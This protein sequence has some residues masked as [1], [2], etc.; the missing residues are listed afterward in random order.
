MPVPCVVPH[1]RHPAFPYQRSLS[2]SLCGNFV[3]TEMWNFLQCSLGFLPCG[4]S[5]ARFL[6][7]GGFGCVSREHSRV[8]VW[9]RRRVRWAAN[10]SVRHF[11]TRVESW[12]PRNPVFVVC[13]DEDLAVNRDQSQFSPRLEINR[14]PNFVWRQC[15]FRGQADGVRSMHQSVGGDLCTPLEIFRHQF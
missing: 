13:E 4:V 5:L 15:F 6:R 8:R 12:V 7:W 10:T 14:S 11:R 9:V 3:A 1:K 2:F